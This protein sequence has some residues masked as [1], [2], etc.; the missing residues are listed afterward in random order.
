LNKISNAIEGFYMEKKEFD[1]W[2]VIE[3]YFG[4]T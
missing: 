2:N 1:A 4:E 3:G